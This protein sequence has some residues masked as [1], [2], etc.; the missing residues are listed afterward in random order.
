MPELT[1]NPLV[2]NIQ[3]QAGQL[4]RERESMQKLLPT[5]KPEARDT[6]QQNYRKTFGEIVDKIKRS[7][8][9][10]LKEEA[11]PV[12]EARPIL[13]AV[14]LQARSFP[15]S[16]SSARRS[17]RPA[18]RWPLPVRRNTASG[19]SSP[20][21]W[22][23]RAPLNSQLQREAREYARL[24]GGVQNER[25]SGERSISRAFCAEIIRVLQRGLN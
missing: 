16:R 18:R 15:C 14:D 13:T 11:P 9:A 24:E 25:I 19:S 2:K 22:A 7:Y 20:A 17:P 21:W 6:F 1:N 12:D 10:L 23:R 5:I 8:A 4:R 3:L